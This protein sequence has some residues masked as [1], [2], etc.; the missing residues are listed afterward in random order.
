[1]EPDKIW[2]ENCGYILFCYPFYQYL[3][4]CNF[5]Q[6]FIATRQ[7]LAETATD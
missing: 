2:G 5:P 4:S 6:D 3:P 7:I 1:M